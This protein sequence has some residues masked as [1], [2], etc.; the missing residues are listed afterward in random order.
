MVDRRGIETHRSIDG[1][2]LG[3][4]S[5]EDGT[6]PEHRPVEDGTWDVEGTRPEHRPVEDG[7]WD[8]EGRG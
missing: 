3:S 6:R 4:W 7:T 2:L 5:V 8:V 1:Y